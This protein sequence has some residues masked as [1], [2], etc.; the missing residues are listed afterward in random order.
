MKREEVVYTIERIEEPDFGCEGRLEGEVV[1]DT[2]YLK[3]EDGTKRIVK[4][5]EKELWQSGLDEGMVVTMDE[6][7]RL[8][9]IM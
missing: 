7:D 8:F 6:N 2:I 4:M 5:E 1:K 3:G 9:Q